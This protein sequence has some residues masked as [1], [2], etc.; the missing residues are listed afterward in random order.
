[1]TGKIEIGAS[2][3][4]DTVTIIMANVP[5]D[6]VDMVLH[7]LGTTMR[8]EFIDG[9]NAQIAGRELGITRSTRTITLQNGKIL[10]VE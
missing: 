4:G 3:D 7:E 8:R 2:I 6:K 10:K 1:M 9:L 5:F